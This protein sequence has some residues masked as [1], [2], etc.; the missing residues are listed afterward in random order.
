MSEKVETTVNEQNMNPTY[1]DA[2]PNVPVEARLLLAPLNHYNNLLPIQLF[3]IK[4]HAY[5]C[6]TF[7]PTVYPNAL[8]HRTTIVNYIRDELKHDL[9]IGQTTQNYHFE[10]KRMF[11]CYT[12]M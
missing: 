10:S 3:L 11:F 1:I 4:Y 7:C 6:T 8:L 5:P 12:V 2:L 9:N